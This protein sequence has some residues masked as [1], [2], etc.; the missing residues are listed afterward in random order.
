MLRCLLINRLVKVR[1]HDDFHCVVIDYYM[2]AIA[3]VDLGFLDAGSLVVE[4]GRDVG[5]RWAQVFGV[6]MEEM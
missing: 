2:S 1:H 4:G 5:A 6:E 3:S